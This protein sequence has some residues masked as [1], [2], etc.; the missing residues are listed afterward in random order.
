MNYDEIIRTGALSN[1]SVACL[2]LV[3]PEIRMLEK[4]QAVIEHLQIPVAFI[5]EE[6]SALLLDTQRSDQARAIA[7]WFDA[8][9]HVGLHAD[10]S[11]FRLGGPCR[12]AAGCPVRN[13]G[14]LVQSDPLEYFCQ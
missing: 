12:L 4:A 6:L 8:R 1:S 7:R 13:R 2:V 9:F 3:H 11:F 5:G 10:S 14:R